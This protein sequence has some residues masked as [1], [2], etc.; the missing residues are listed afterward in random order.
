MRALKLVAA[1]VTLVVAAGCASA[2]DTKTSPRPAG[3]Q[4][5]PHQTAPSSAPTPL[6][7]QR[8]AAVYAAVLQ[9]FLSNEGTIPADIIGSVYLVNRTGTMS[10]RG[11][12]Q[13]IDHIVQDQLS[14]LLGQ[15]YRLRWV[16]SVDDAA[17]TG[18]LDCDL[19]DK[20]DVV[21]SLGQV[22]PKGDRVKIGVDG[23]ADC[24]LAGG[25]LYTLRD[26]PSGWR[27][28]KSQGTWSA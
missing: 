15:S 9:R 13:P 26:G 24:G 8:Q 7:P 3:T 1:T 10:D 2:S 18:R 17:I 23:L 11:G 25:F 6:T 28:T 27:V 16:H 4:T 12:G 14:G 20:R 19:D 22:P 5:S 21:I